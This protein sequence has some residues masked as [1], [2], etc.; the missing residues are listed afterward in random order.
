MSG[1]GVYSSESRLRSQV[2]VGKRRA[3]QHLKKRRRGKKA[4]DRRRV[5]AGARLEAGADR[6]EVG[7]AVALQADDLEA[8]EIFARG[9]LF[10]LGQHAAHELGPDA[11]LLVGVGGVV[12]LDDVRRGGG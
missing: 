12:L 2:V 3:G 1:S 7:Q 11:V 8:I 9:V 4:A 5:P 6:G 10:Q